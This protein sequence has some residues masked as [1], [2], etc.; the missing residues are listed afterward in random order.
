MTVDDLKTLLNNGI[1]ILQ[2]N[3]AIA[4]DDFLTKVQKVVV[5]LGGPSGQSAYFTDQFNTIL[6]DVSNV[7]DIERKLVPITDNLIGVMQALQNHPIIMHLIA[8][9]L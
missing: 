8:R 7:V 1:G 3:K 4:T 5:D 9:F 6:G 2:D